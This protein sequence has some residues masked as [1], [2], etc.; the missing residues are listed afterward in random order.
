[1]ANPGDFCIDIGER[2]GSGIP[3]IFHV[4][5]EQGWKEP[6][7]TEPAEPDRIALLLSLLKNESSDKGT[8]TTS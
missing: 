3:N 5:R 8:K 1:M 2:A 7:I 6:I 4:W